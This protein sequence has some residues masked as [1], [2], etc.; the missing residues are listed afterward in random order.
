MGYLR[1]PSRRQK[2]S[3]RTKESPQQ[4]KPAKRVAP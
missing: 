1:M 4:P 3:E 2:D